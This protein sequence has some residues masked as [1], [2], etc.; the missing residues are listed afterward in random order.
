MAR[1]KKN[2]SFKDTLDT[3]QYCHRC[4]WRR[5]VYDYSLPNGL[6]TIVHYRCELCRLVSVKLFRKDEVERELNAKKH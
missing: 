4:H 5:V 1:R 3:K 2:L 6:Y